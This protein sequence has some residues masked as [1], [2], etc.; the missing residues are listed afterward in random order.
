[1]NIESSGKKILKEIAK[2][3]YLALNQI[4]NCLLSEINLILDS[5]KINLEKVNKRNDGFVTVKNNKRWVFYTGEKS[6]KII[7]RIKPVI[8]HRV[9]SING[10][11]ANIGKMKGIVRVLKNI[12]SD[13][14]LKVGKMKKG[15][16][17]VTE[18]TR[19]QLIDACKKASAIITDE[20]GINCHAS[21]ISRE[22]NIPCVVGT[23]I[24][25]QVLKDGD[26]VE[27]DADN[28]LVKMLK[29]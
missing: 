7:K 2:R 4:E 5:K 17:L 18:M 12:D 26:I 20:G 13:L 1:M 15:D 11:V 28:G 29:K 25:T 21:I 16:I 23:K 8:K 24:A 22:L 14:G 10:N 6:K 9:T 19:P 3:N 27:V